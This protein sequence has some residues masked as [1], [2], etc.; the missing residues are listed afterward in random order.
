MS[1]PLD[2][3]MPAPG[4]DTF[5]EEDLAPGDEERRAARLERIDRGAASVAV[6]ALGLWWGGLLALGACAAPMVF[7]FAPYPYSG[8]AMG[9]AF[10]RFD[11]LAIGCGV[12]VLG[13]E[14]VRTWLAR[15]NRGWLPRLRRY[16]TIV[17]AGATVYSATLLTP[18]IMQLHSEGV[19]RRVGPEGERLERIHDSAELIGKITVPGAMLLTVLHVLAVGRRD[20]D[21]EPVLAPRAPGGKRAA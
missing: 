20:D 5:S 15:G 1:A 21:D 8:Q 13:C 12:V 14:M 2:K 16:L 11:G 4:E 3:D 17:L 6:L 9:A 7:E 19:R 18:Q 10:A